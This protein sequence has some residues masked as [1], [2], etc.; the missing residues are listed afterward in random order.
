MINCVND[1]HMA[2]KTD[3]SN[4]FVSYLNFL[5]N[6]NDILVWCGRTWNVAPS[7]AVT[8]LSHSTLHLFKIPDSSVLSSDGSWSQMYSREKRTSRE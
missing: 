8:W 7:Q 6:S 2:P 1:A 3:I 5:N 4:V